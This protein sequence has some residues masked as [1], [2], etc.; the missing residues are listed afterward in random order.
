MK[1]HGHT[2]HDTPNMMLCHKGRARHADALHLGCL[3]GGGGEF[4]LEIPH[5]HKNTNRSHFCVQVKGR[6]G[7]GSVLELE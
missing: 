4:E 3:A 7:R 1:K 2:D 5:K 6:G